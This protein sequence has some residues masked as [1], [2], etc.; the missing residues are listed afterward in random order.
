M[1]DFQSKL[2]SVT[3]V[4]DG[5][6]PAERVETFDASVVNVVTVADFLGALKPDDQ[7]AL[8]LAA[9]MPSMHGLPPGEHS[10]WVFW[11]LSARHCDGLPSTKGEPLSTHCL[12]AGER[13][14][15]EVYFIVAAP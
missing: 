15:R 5:E 4:V 1:E 7:Q 11:T 3:V 9:V 14:M 12:P 2:Q 8:P 6:T 13:F 10:A